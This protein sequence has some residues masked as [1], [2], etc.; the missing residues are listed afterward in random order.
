M[1]RA[2]LLLLAV[3]ALV[4]CLS[5]AEA[6]DNRRSVIAP[7]RFEGERDRP[8]SPLDEEKA[9]SYREEL[10]GQLRDQETRDIGRS[11]TGAARLFETRRELGRM[12]SLLNSPPRPAPPMVAPS[13]DDSLSVDDR[14]S[15]ERSGGHPQPTP[16]MIEEREAARRNQP[17]EPG[18]IPELRPVYDLYGNRIQ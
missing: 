5:A 10:R 14:R 2:P 8:T 17:R 13:R 1:R 12:D 16:G 4:A 3:A 9:R 15:F 7:F 6:A 18:T 11:A